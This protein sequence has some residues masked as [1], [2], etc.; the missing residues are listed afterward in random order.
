[1]VGP[2]LPEGA[3]ETIR[4]SSRGVGA[5]WRGRCCTVGVAGIHAGGTPQRR[6]RRGLGGKSANRRPPSRRGDP[7]FLEG[8]PLTIRD[9]QITAGNAAVSRLIQD[10]DQDAPDQPA[11]P[12][13]QRDPAPAKAPANEEVDAAIQ[14]KFEILSRQIEGAEEDDPLEAA[15]VERTLL[16]FQFTMPAK[17]ETRDAVRVHL[18]ACDKAAEKEDATLAKLGKDAQQAM[19]QHPQ[20]FPS[21][22]ADILA[23][24]L[25]IA[26]DDASLAS[27]KQRSWENLNQVGERVPKQVAE[28]GLPLSLAEVNA[29]KNFELKPEHA[30]LPEGEV[31]RDF[32]LAALSYRGTAV[33]AEVARWWKQILKALVN[34]VRNAEEIV[35]PA[36]LAQITGAKGRMSELL[37]GSMPPG[38]DQFRQLDADVAKLHELAMLTTLIGVA[39]GLHKSGELWQESA[40]LFKT[41]LAEADKIVAGWGTVE[42]LKHSFL[43]MIDRD[44]LADTLLLMVHVIEDNIGEI[45]EKLLI[46]MG[47]Q[48]I[49]IVDIIVDAYLAV[50]MGIDLAK[51]LYDLGSA[52]VDGSTAKSV[53]ALQKSSVHLT[54]AL[55]TA[56]LRILMDYFGLSATLAQ[57]EARVTRLLAEAPSLTPR[58]AAKI[59]IKESEG[60]G[61]PGTKIDEPTA[62]TKG[63]AKDVEPA[64]GGPKAKTK[65]PRSPSKLTADEIAG[66]VRMAKNLPGGGR[67]K[68][69]DDGRL[70]I[71]HSP[72]QSIAARFQTELQQVSDEAQAFRTRLQTIAREEQAAVTAGDAAAELD[73]FNAADVLNTELAAFRLT[74]ISAATGVSEA[75]LADLIA[76]AADDGNLVQRLL[77]RVNN[78][79]ARVRPLLEAANRDLNVLNKLE[80]A[81]DQFPGARVPPGGVVLD[82]RFAPYANT[83]NMP[84]FIERHTWEGFDFHQIARDNTF[85]PPGTTAA[86]MQDGIA[87]VLSQMRRAYD[88]FPYNEV[89]VYTIEGGPLDGLTVQ[90]VRDDFEIVQFFPLETPGT[91]VINFS[92]EELWGIGFFLNRLP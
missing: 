12:A 76:L 17:L 13:L 81:L 8:G 72:C 41:K 15:R 16:L 66:G 11:A 3:A 55:M 80:G 83:A 92:R 25:D 40:A 84:H 32:A 30:K 49:P 38:E 33:R 4:T 24:T 52:F 50:D 48:A 77:G 54:S 89:R 53:I 85:F 58:E 57:L 19:V 61:A 67:L 5:L 88:K 27:E 42:T 71:C 64:G 87:R 22:W 51:A 82:G 28:Y 91:N 20:A 56:P 44:Y 62:T 46:F 47:L 45:M 29:A 78:N 63:G 43:L 75:L 73:A 90:I 37:R 9:L 18:E 68:L 21:S 1:M 60:G 31:V 69:L 79:P 7:R 86:D 74:R 6:P 34:S 35:D 26:A 14:E 23:K 36:E 10:R 59:A 65:P 39:S 2:A 70:V